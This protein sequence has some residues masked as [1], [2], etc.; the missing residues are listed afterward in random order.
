VPYNLYFT[1]GNGREVKSLRSP[2]DNRRDTIR[3]VRMLVE[4]RARAA[5]LDVSDGGAQTFAERVAAC[6]LGET[7]THSVLGISFRTERVCA[8][9]STVCSAG[10]PCPE[11]S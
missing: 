11:C 10:A 1:R 4:E 9:G 6:P 5:G 8:L 7:V 2:Y 3:T